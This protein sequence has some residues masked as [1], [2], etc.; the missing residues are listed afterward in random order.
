MS[1]AVS[2]LSFSYGV[3]PILK[4]I[5]FSLGEGQLYA[6]LG[7]N[8]AGKTT[9]FRCLLG[10][11]KDYNGSITIDGDEV[12][13]LTPRQ[14]SHRIAY[15]PQVHYPAFRYCVLEMVLMGTTHR[16][17]AV[18]SPGKCENNDALQALQTLG[19]EHLANRDYGTL[20][21]GEQ[22]MV[23]I[24]RALVQQTKLLLMDEP[25]ASLDYGNQMRVLCAVRRLA[26][27]GY[28]IL[29]STHNPQHALS[30]AD[31]VLALAG[32]TLAADGCAREVISPALLKTLYGV[33]TE[34]SPD[35]RYILPLEVLS[36]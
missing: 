13:S 36:C 5:S 20:S 22:Q 7:A 16:L 15:I 33:E 31:R 34:F 25:T 9:L 23:L 35:G 21:G 6:L 1:L 30:Y 8:G 14:L 11:N 17:S 18:A 2:N 10:L 26:H 12:R 19:I 24:A 3:T 4:T 28:T 27:E 32:G 29:L